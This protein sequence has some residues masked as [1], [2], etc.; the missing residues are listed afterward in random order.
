ML[1]AAPQVVHHTC[2]YNV[3]LIYTSLRLLSEAKTGAGEDLHRDRCSV[4]DAIHLLVFSA[5][6]QSRQEMRARSKDG[7]SIRDARD[8]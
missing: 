6:R 8:D 1:G 4:H 5:A 7:M 3:W 2:A